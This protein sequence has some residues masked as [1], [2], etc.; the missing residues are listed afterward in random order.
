VKSSCDRQCVT[1]SQRVLPSDGRNSS[2]RAKPGLDETAPARFANRSAN[3]S[4]RS[5]GTST[6]LMATNTVRS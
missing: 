4:A 1:T 2:K 5:A 6:A 3:A